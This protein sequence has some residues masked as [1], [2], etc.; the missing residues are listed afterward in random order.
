MHPAGGTNNKKIADLEGLHWILGA[1][2]QLFDSLL[3]NFTVNMA[4]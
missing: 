4:S 2:Y 1:M 3:R